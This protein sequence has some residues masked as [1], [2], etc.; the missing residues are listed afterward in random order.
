MGWPL[1]KGAS[2]T[3]SPRV[4][5]GTILLKGMFACDMYFKET[6]GHKYQHKSLKSKTEWKRY[7]QGCVLGSFRFLKRFLKF[8]WVLSSDNPSGHNGYALY[9]T[10]GQMARSCF[11]FFFFSYQQ[12]ERRACGVQISVWLRKEKD[13]NWL[14]FSARDSSGTV[15]ITLHSPS[16]YILISSLCIRCVILEVRK[17]SHMKL[18]N[19][20]QG[21]HTSY[22]R[23]QWD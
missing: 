22:I 3:W 5:S 6:W 21:L 1:A 17:L 23:Q 2:P 9:S 16:N 15:L 4:S 18:S 11:A 12:C 10:K 7:P 14:R 20:L 19:K 13:S 8:L